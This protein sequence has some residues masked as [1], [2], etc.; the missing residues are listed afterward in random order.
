[1]YCS[2]ENAAIMSTATGTALRGQCHSV[3]YEYSVVNQSHWMDTNS[4]IGRKKSLRIILHSVLIININRSY[5]YQ[6]I[7]HLIHQQESYNERS[8]LYPK[9][10]DLLWNSTS[11]L[12]KK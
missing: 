12:N 6:F 2:S 8:V 11:H 5:C 9:K 3:V 7:R 4:H 10:I 1:M